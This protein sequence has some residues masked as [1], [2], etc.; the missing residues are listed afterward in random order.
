MPRCMY[1][2]VAAPYE[3]TITNTN[4]SCSIIKMYHSVA[5][6]QYQIQYQTISLQ[7]HKSVPF[8]V[9]P[10]VCTMPRCM[11][12]AVAAPYKYTITSTSTSC[13]IIKMYHSVAAPHICT[14]SKCMFHLVAAPYICTMPICMYQT[15]AA[16][17]KYTI[18]TTNIFCSNIK[19]Y[20]FIAAPQKSAMSKCMYYSVAAPYIC[21]MPI[22]EPWFQRYLSASYGCTILFAAPP[23]CTMSESMYHFVAAPYI[24]TIP[25]QE[26]RLQRQ[27]FAY[28]Y[29]LNTLCTGEVCHTM[30]LHTLEISRYTMPYHCSN[31]GTIEV[32]LKIKWL[33]TL[34]LN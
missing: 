24:C 13:S 25:I 2:T 9:A 29:H 28:H 17:Y 31:F 33:Y 26:P 10:Q 11:Y 16:S 15:V 21:T 8:I 7:P 20:H 19:M 12:Q 27:G 4:T 22:Q 32:T 5:A 23:L 6:P 18:T 1:Q 30:P 34:W 3:Y 14:I